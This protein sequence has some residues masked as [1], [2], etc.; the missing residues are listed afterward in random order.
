MAR[1]EKRFQTDCNQ[2]VGI[3]ICIFH[4]PHLMVS[5]DVLHR[6]LLLREELPRVIHQ[7]AHAY[8]GTWWANL[9]TGKSWWNTAWWKSW[10]ILLF[11][12][13]I[14]W[15]EGHVLSKPLPGALENSQRHTQRV[16][17]VAQHRDLNSVKSWSKAGVLTQN[18]WSNIIQSPELLY[19]YIWESDF[20]KRLTAT[21]VNPHGQGWEAPDLEEVA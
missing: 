8:L 9:V 20:V 12:E 13:L 7:Q 17:E 19:I 3:H 16:H 21:T 6:R 1:F 14:G 10:R 4:T 11:V 5:Y 2:L 18:A 15:L